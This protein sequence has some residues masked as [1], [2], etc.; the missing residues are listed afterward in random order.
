MAPPHRGAVESAD[1][2]P[3]SWSFL[4]RELMRGCLIVRGEPHEVNVKCASTRSEHGTPGPRR[5]QARSPAATVLG[6]P[7]CHPDERLS[8]RPRG[9]GWS[10][11]V[12]GLGVPRT[13]EGAAE[14]R[15]PEAR[16]AVNRSSKTGTGVP[17]T[18]F[19]KHRRRP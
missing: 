15:A 16:I 4:A 10:E 13:A 14:R 9:A 7:G 2:V 11:A 19:Q 8:S 18:N 6:T 1:E 12:R 5:R 17:G 3:R